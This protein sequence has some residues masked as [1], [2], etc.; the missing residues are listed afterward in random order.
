MTFRHNDRGVRTSPDA[1]FSQVVRSQAQA[2]RQ[3]QAREIEA[4][5]D[6]ARQRMSLLG[7]LA[8]RLP[9]RKP[10]NGTEGASDDR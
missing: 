9:G 8:L 6:R 1:D 5:L 3:Q 2:R 10:A 7:R 4:E